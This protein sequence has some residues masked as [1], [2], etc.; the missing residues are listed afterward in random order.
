MVCG[1]ERPDSAISVAHRPVRGLED[2]FPA[3]ARFN[4]RYCNDRPDCTARAH[5]EGPWR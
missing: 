3:G 1:E 2:R 4:V 5:E